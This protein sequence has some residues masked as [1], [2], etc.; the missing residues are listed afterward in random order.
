MLGAS[1][2][3]LVVA[4]TESLVWRLES[5]EVKLIAFRSWD[6]KNEN[7]FSTKKSGLTSV[8]LK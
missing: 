7:S 2:L 6:V 5:V 8:L 4:T 1:A 3:L